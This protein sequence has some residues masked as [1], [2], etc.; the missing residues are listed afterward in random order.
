MPPSPVVGDH[1]YI[2]L[3]VVLSILGQ[4]ADGFAVG[5][6]VAVDPIKP[7][8][9]LIN[10]ILQQRRLQGGLCIRDEPGRREGGRGEL[11]TSQLL[12]KLHTLHSEAE[13]VLKISI[14]QKTHWR[15]HLSHTLWRVCGCLNMHV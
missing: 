14:Q 10:L 6:L 9:F 8:L 3:V 11:V 5:L 12:E 4:V 1:V 7:N 13:L 15:K 2:Q